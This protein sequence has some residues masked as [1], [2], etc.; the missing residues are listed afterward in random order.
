MKFTPSN[1][2]I[3]NRQVSALFLKGNWTACL[4]RL[5]AVFLL[6]GMQAFT[7]GADAVELPP[8]YC[9]G[10]VPL[11]IGIEAGTGAGEVWKEFGVYAQGV[12]IGIS[13]TGVM[14]EHESLTANYAGTLPDGGFDHNYAWFD[15]VEQFPD[16]YDRFGA[17]TFVT[18]VIAGVDPV[19]C[20]GVAPQA[21]YMVCNPYDSLGIDYVDEHKKCLGWFLEP[22]DLNEENPRPELRPDV[23]YTNECRTCLGDELLAL[24]QQLRAAGTL[25]VAS[26]RNV[27]PELTNCGQIVA[28][29]TTYPN[30][31]TVSAL[32]TSHEVL[33]TSP[34]GPGSFLGNL[35]QKPNLA[36]VGDKVESAFIGGPD[37]YTLDSG[38]DVAAGIATG[39]VALVLSANPELKGQP[40]L[41]EDIL[42]STARARP[43]AYCNEGNILV[44]EVVVPNW[45]FGYGELNVYEAVKRAMEYPYGGCPT[46]PLPASQCNTNG[47]STIFSVSQNLTETADAAQEI[48]FFYENETALPGQFGEP[49]Q[50]AGERFRLCVYDTVDDVAVPSGAVLNSG[51]E[52]GAADDL[53]AGQWS[54]VTSPDVLEYNFV[55]PSIE[56]NDGIVRARLN[57]GRSIFHI[58]GTGATLPLA[59]VRSRMDLHG[60]MY[61]AAD[62]LIVQAHSSASGTC[63]GAH[64]RGDD[65]KQNTNDSFFGLHDVIEPRV[66]VEQ[67]AGQQDPVVAEPTAATVHFTAVFS[68]QVYGLSGE[69]ITLGGTAG[70]TTAVVARSGETTYDI[71]VSGMTDYGTV[72][73][74]IGA[75]V[76]EDFAG[77]LNAASTSI[78]NQVT[79][80]RYTI[81]YP[82]LSSHAH[83][84]I[85]VPATGDA[86]NLNLRAH[87]NRNTGARDVE[88]VLSLENLTVGELPENCTLIET[89]GA[90]AQKVRCD[91]GYI[92][93]FTSEW[94]YLPNVVVSAG[95]GET[96]TYSWAITAINEQ[97]NALENNQSEGEFVAVEKG[98]TDTDGDGMP[99]EWEDENGLWKTDSLDGDLDLD[100]DGLNS[101]AEYKAGTDPNNPDTDGD[102]VPDGQDPAPLDPNA[103]TPR[104]DPETADSDDDGL[105]DS[106]EATLGTDPNNP[107]SDYDGLY[108]GAE[109][110]ETGTDPL[111][112]DT[113]G[114]GLLDGWDSQPNTKAVNAIGEGAYP[115]EFEVRDEIG[116]GEGLSFRARSIR[117]VRSKLEIKPGATAAFVAEQF[118]GFP[119]IPRG[120]RVH[121]VTKKAAEARSHAPKE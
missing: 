96:A 51:F 114:D 45:D 76:S 11:H 32:T 15:A 1:V 54:R 86:L 115:E 58:L 111:D 113:S 85:Q 42:Y 48:Q 52:L 13:H 90:V 46:Q 59:R 50:N 82:D 95:A 74:S 26:T 78:D 19:R 9:T 8:D 107:D 84:N 38:S 119:N 108:D 66:S 33:P 117:F 18:G 94:T 34:L 93:G 4:P 100:Q 106:E 64:L 79:L 104:Y 62:G 99:D 116:E 5:A 89:P 112:N 67:A 16:P 41:V 7:A 49:D 98:K 61:E 17:G 56:G 88:G 53:T 24:T 103:P 70:P 10:E 47:T 30:V 12:R 28:A 121:I 77:N 109:V 65:I 29:P 20:F 81:A 72:T 31:I 102:G 97:D 69:S 23:V 92:G 120:A 57:E 36:T 63:W 101:L 110:N 68:E 27:E 37:A 43:F 6:F 39:A 21:K 73:A 105:T 118:E 83:R 87:N 35:L 22:H 2:N 91:L 55:G 60:K 75:G 14:A 80:H 3:R 40:R 44:P 25:V 71:A